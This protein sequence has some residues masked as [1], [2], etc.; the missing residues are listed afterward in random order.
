MDP[1]PN[2]FG[3]VDPDFKSRGILFHFEFFFR[4]KLNFSSLNLKK[5]LISKV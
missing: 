2:S 1:D 5:E 3:S 4:S